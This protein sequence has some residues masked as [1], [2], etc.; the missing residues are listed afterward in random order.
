VVLAGRK[1]AFSEM[2]FVI[3]VA[4]GPDSTNV[5][6][7]PALVP[8]CSHSAKSGMVQPPQTLGGTPSALVGNYLADQVY[9]HLRE[10]L[11]ARSIAPACSRNRAI[12]CV[13]ALPKNRPYSLLNWDAPAYPTLRLAVPASIIGVR[14]T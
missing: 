4:A 11:H 1:K 7:P 6:A 10:S 2:G 5:I 13:G 12:S 9:G 3:F 8:V 14:P